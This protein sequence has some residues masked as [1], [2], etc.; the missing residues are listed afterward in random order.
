MVL[1]S[2][3]WKATKDGKIQ[4]SSYTYLCMD[5]GEERNSPIIVDDCE[6][7]NRWGRYQVEFRNLIKTKI[8]FRSQRWVYSV[9]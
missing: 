2:Q 4:H 7:S 9:N 5:S 1:F 3:K 8:S 6:G